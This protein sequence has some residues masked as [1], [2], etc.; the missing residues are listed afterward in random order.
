MPAH[1]PAPLFCKQPRQHFSGLPCFSDISRRGRS[2]RGRCANLSQIARQ[3]CDK[4]PVQFF[5]SCLWRCEPFSPLQ[6]SKTLETPNLSKICPSDCFGGF[7]SGGLKFGKICQ[8]LKNGNFRT[9]FDKFFQISVPLTG[10]P[11]NNRWDK[12]WTNLGFWAF[13]KAVR[14]KRVRNIRGRV[15]K[16]VANLK[17]NVGQFYAN[18]PFQ[19]PLLRIS[20]FWG[21]V[22]GRRDRSPRLT[23]R[24]LTNIVFRRNRFT[25]TPAWQGIFIRGLE[26]GCLGSPV[27]HF[28]HWKPRKHTRTDL[29]YLFLT[30]FYGRLI[31]YH[32]WCW[33]AGGAA[34]VKTG[35]GNN[36]PRKYQR[37]PRNCY[38]YLCWNLATF[39]PFSAGTGNF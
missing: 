9:N 5:R 36:F 35:T 13:L 34:P 33:C 30:S 17:V 28:A 1:W 14:G 3:I 16:I 29:F 27:A 23:G 25:S 10:T 8:N 4:L 19:C 22:P 24:T 12:F 31:F 20:E 18:T 38:Q 11:Q 39:L 37:I 15:R 21:P 2:Q 7:Q 26:G 32:Y 6:P